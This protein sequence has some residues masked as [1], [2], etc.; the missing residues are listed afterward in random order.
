MK[1]RNFGVTVFPA[2]NLRERTMHFLKYFVSTTAAVS[3][4]MLATVFTPTLAVS[5]DKPTLTVYTYDSFAADWGPAPKVKEAF[6]KDC[7]C[8]LEFVASDSAIGSLRKIQL[9][10]ANTKADVLLGL[11]T[12][13]AEAA[14]ATGLF[15]EHNVATTSLTLPIKWED[16]TFLP[17]DYSYFAF[18]YDNTIV[19]DPP[20]SFAELAAMPDDFK[21]IIQDPRS[22]TPGL[23]LVLWVNAVFGEKSADYWK[24]IAPKIQTVTKGWSDAYGLFLKGEADMVLSYSTS[25][26]Y[27]L[28]AEEKTNYSSAN[29]SDGHYAQIEVAAV[30]KS[31]KQQPLAKKFMAFMLSDTFQDIIPTTNWTYPA[32]KTAAGLPKGFETLQIPEKAILTEGVEVEKKRKALIEEWLTVLGK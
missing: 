9:E 8:I 26:A 15:V 4:A 1:R 20:E 27:H 3:I 30:L 31:S 11:D 6:E 12:N 23:G 18:V 24:A 25:P 29:F 5:A 22:S 14:R 2:S 19:K 16:K 28:I 7:D 21:I 13:I 17:F 32:T 10:G